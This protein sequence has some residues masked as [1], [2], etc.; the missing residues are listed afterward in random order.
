MTS[1]A[2]SF[3]Q[4]D[5]KTERVKRVKMSPHNQDFIEKP[6]LKVSFLRESDL[7]Q[8]MPLKNAQLLKEKMSSKRQRFIYFYSKESTEAQKR[9]Q[10]KNSLKASTIAEVSLLNGL[11]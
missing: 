9:M 3:R 11:A 2:P 8:N 1:N 7:K 10:G 4:S 5:L 6:S